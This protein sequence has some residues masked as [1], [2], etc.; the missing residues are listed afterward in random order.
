MQLEI[1]SSLKYCRRKQK[2]I[3]KTLDDIKKAIT[4][5]LGSAFANTSKIVTN[6]DGLNWLDSLKDTMGRYLLK[7]NLDQTS[8]IRYQLAVGA[9]NVPIVVV[10]NI[11]LQSDVT[12]AKKRGI[13]MLCGDVKRRRKK[14]FDRQKNL[15]SGIKYRVC[16]RI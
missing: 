2:Q 12:T 13:P 15:H 11:V 16:N 10:P 6:D 9:T 14:P 3:M 7:P 4:V 5:T 1:D 8:P